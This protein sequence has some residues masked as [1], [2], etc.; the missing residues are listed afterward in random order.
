MGRST[1][2]R[3][4]RDRIDQNGSKYYSENSD[5]STISGTRADSHPELSS[6]HQ[7]DPE[8]PGCRRNGD[9]VA[10]AVGLIASVF[11]ADGRS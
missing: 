6:R 3:R 1:E 5:A 9:P 2:T 10:A 8:Q 4:K 7:T 11:R